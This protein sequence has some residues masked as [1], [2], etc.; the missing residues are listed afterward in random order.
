VKEIVEFPFSAQETEKKGVRRKYIRR[1]HYCIFYVIDDDEIVVV[2]IS[3]TLLSGCL[4][5]G[6][7]GKR[8]TVRRRV[9]VATS[10]ARDSATIR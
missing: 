10:M 3:N 1:L 9:E 6:C 8:I 2:L 7:L 4:G 5:S